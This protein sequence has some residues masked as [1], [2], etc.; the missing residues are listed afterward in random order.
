MAMK[1]TLAFAA[2]WC[3][4]SVAF[5]AEWS[6]TWEPGTGEATPS[7]EVAPFKYGKVWAYAIE[8][9]DNPISMVKAAK[10]LFAARHYTDAPPGVAG[11]N[12]RPFVGGAAVIVANLGAGNRTLVQWEEIRE[13][14]AAG[15]GVI[16]HSYAHAGRTWGDPPEILTP[17]QLRT[18]HF[19]SQTVLANELG[20]APT[21]FVYPNGYTDYRAYLAEFGMRSGSRVG[22]N[23]KNNE[24]YAGKVDVTELGR[25]YLDEGPWKSNGKAAVDHGIPEGGPKPGRV[26]IDFTHGIDEN[27]TSENHQR[28]AARLD[29]IESRWG[30]KG[31]DSLWCAQT[32]EVLE[33][34]AARGVAK[35]EAERGRVRVTLPDDA[36]GAALTLVLVGV[37]EDAKL[38]A[39]E[40][41][42]V[43]RQGDRVWVTSPT[44]GTPG[45]PA[46]GPKVQ[47]SYAGELKQLTFPSPV[48]I[49]GVR[50]LQRGPTA[51]DFELKIDAVD[52][53]G[54]VTPLVPA[55]QAKLSKR[56][57]TWR[58]FAVAP[59]A[60]PVTAT[61]LR[62]TTDKSLPQ[63][64][65]WEAVR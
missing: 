27:P 7:V 65:V 42:V 39:P 52:A 34:V 36:P 37:S 24:V 32:G 14:Q 45:A 22:G 64:E 20:R 55:D 59:N 25:T 26:F 23:V 19:W 2:A 47:R 63:L 53:S 8:M 15:W 40:G 48:A 61:E 38:A 18:D 12:E 35:V 30:A 41:G 1:R 31:D 57:G 54:K 60:E 46:P 21:H 9:D 58:L 43:Y 49:A 50:V 5:A 4:A 11:G 13:L 56:W 62:V 44:I 10:P 16:N 6:W 51:D 17:E 29:L 33:Y 3:G 28:W